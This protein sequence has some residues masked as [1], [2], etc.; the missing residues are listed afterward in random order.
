MRDLLAGHWK[1][2]VLQVPC[3][4][5]SSIVRFLLT[6]FYRQLMAAIFG[7]SDRTSEVHLEPNLISMWPCVISPLS[8]SVFA[9]FS[10]MR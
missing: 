8:M 2:V 6:Q 3:R 9:L 4:I 5:S 7:P 10:R 1:R